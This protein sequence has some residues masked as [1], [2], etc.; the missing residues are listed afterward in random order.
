MGNYGS[1]FKN[2]P[3]LHVQDTEC[4]CVYLA[5]Y[6]YNTQDWA[7]MNTVPASFIKGETF[8]EHWSDYRIFK[9]DYSKKQFTSTAS[10]CNP[11]YNM[12]KQEE[13]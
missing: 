10:L 5:K 12:W 13:I 8:P 7:V 6:Q 9:N 11:K 1:A 4:V 3:K 2:D